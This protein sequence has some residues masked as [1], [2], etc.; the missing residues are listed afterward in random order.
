MPAP[1]A[2]YNGPVDFYLGVLA[3]ARGEPALALEHLRVAAA[4]AES[5]DASPFV[6]AARLEEGRVLTE[7]G[8][9]DDAIS[10]L[11]A[12]RDGARAMG[13]ALHEL[14]AADYLARS[15]P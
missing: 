10:P 2:G 12:A 5:S 14:Q 3:A 8:R 13:M 15:T 9:F 7:T 4:T 11:T 1:Y 6:I